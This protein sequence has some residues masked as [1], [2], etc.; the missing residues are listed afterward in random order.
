MK[1]IQSQ[2]RHDNSKKKSGGPAPPEQA[3]LPSLLHL[4]FGYNAIDEDALASLASAFPSLTS[5]DLCNNYLTDTVAVVSTIQRDMPLLEHLLLAGNSLALEF[6]YRSRCITSLP[7]I[8]RFDDLDLDEDDTRAARRAVQRHG[9]KVIGAAKSTSGDKASAPEVGDGD[10]PSSPALNESPLLGDKSRAL[11][12]YVKVGVLKGMPGPV[13]TRAEPSP[14]DVETLGDDAP[15]GPVSVS[16]KCPE[17]E[18]E[19]ETM[20]QD[21]EAIDLRYFL[22]LVPPGSKALPQTTAAKLWAFEPGVRFAEFVTLRVPLSADFLVGCQFRGLRVEIW[23]SLPGKK[24]E[25]ASNE[26]KEAL[27]A[28]EVSNSS[29]A[30]DEKATCEDANLIESLPPRVD[31]IVGLGMVD[32]SKFCDPM[33]DGTAEVSESATLISGPSVDQPDLLGLRDMQR[34]MSAA[35]D[36]TADKTQVENGKENTVAGILISH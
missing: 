11:Q 33:I 17:T 5:L 30:E 20:L 19:S 16:Y 9:M 22:R 1:S 35:A 27:A 7:Q 34:A 26:G 18:E 15:P 28:P 32:I 6:G 13:V 3:Q 36:E 2:S 4:G 23:A 29:E 10:G 24:E 14:E 31:T 8:T 25:Q 12:F 21:A